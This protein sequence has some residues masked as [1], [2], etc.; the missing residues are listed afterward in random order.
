M[1][2]IEAALALL[3]PGGTPV[4]EV[5]GSRR[6][7]AAAIAGVSSAKRLVL[8]DGRRLS[9]RRLTRLA[10]EAGLVVDRELVV[11]P[12]LRTAAFVVEDS[13]ESLTW[14]WN[15]GFAT[16][17]PGEVA[18]IPADHGHDVPRPEPPPRPLGRSA[19]GRAHGHRPPTMTTSTRQTAFP[20]LGAVEDVLRQHLGD[21]T[22]RL[23]VVAM[24]RDD[25]PKAVV[26][27]T[28]SGATTPV[29]R[30]Q[31]SPDRGAAGSVRAEAAALEQLGSSTPVSSAG[32]SP[33]CSPCTRPRRARSS[34]RR[35]RRVGRSRSTTTAGTTRV[36]AVTCGPTST[37][38][39]GGS[40]G[41]TASRSPPQPEAD[42]AAALES[43]W[44]DEVG[45]A[46]AQVCR[47]A[48]ARV[49]DL[50]T[51][52]VTHGDFW[53]GNILRTGRRVTGVVDWEHARRCA[54]LWDRVRFALA[55][56]LYLDR[57]T[58]S[59]ARVHGHAGLRAGA[60]GDPVRHC[61]G[62][63]M[64][65]A[66]VAD[67]I[68]R[69][70][71]ARPEHDGVAGRRARGSRRGG[72]DERRRRVRP[73]ARVLLAEGGRDHDGGGRAHDDRTGR[74]VRPLPGAGPWSRRRGPCASSSRQPS[75]ACRSSRP[76]VLATPHRADLPILLAMGGV[77][78]WLSSNGVR[79]HVPY[80]AGMWLLVLA[81]AVAAL[82]S[83]DVAL[84]H[85][86]R[87]GPV[88]PALGRHHRQR[89][90]CRPLPRPTRVRHVVLE[91]DRQRRPARG[92]SPRRDPVARRPDHPGRLAVRPDLRRP[93]PRRQLL[94]RLP[95]RRPRLAIPAPPP[96][97]RRDRPP[98]RLA[99]VFTGSTAP[100]SAW[101]SASASGSSSGHGGRAVPSPRPGSRASW[102]RPPG[103]ARHVGRLGVGAGE[104]R[105]QRSGPARLVRSRGTR[106]ARTG[107]SSSPKAYRL[108]WDGDSRRCRPRADEGG[109]GVDPCPLRQGG[110][111]RLHGDARR[112]RP[113][114]RRRPRRPARVRGGTAGARR[115][116]PRTWHGRGGPGRSGD[117]GR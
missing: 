48:R 46:A 53:C 97:A 102:R 85:G 115:G 21:G 15:A 72:D 84:D 52:H 71:R 98:P 45:M 25:H 8:L 41:C 19:R 20:D 4:V 70:A 76:P 114:R 38:Q 2:A 88:P 16:V 116:T 24:S 103:R 3:V 61:W 23:A 43:R 64:V 99:T 111:Q 18:R 86:P 90:A 34:S 92:R 100:C 89:R 39:P 67:F 36:V 51:G 40:P 80:A 12:G 56:T 83:R 106:R 59:G 96:R 66:G 44:P 68:A 5:R 49:G 112:A 57:H 27:A 69:R 1:S 50:D 65:S 73:R 29:L 79:L 55:Y 104:R 35:S 17:P 26:M 101:W 30:G 62:R 110:A 74:C 14:F 13:V 77:L 10:R 75:R 47:S 113:H 54:P 82:A 91:R 31:A 37:Q 95:V 60:W 22:V 33:A 9:A 7:S 93:Q 117:R 78:L 108:F 94:R 81:G 87:T 63:G 11:L 107:R 58:P 109:P 6:G 28:P 105:R 32:R 42:G